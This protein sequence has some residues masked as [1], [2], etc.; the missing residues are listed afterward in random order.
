L[1]TIL[2]AVSLLSIILAYP[3]SA[4][5]RGSP[6]VIAEAG[7]GDIKLYN[8]LGQLIGG[9][10]KTHFDSDVG[11]EDALAVGDVNGDGLNDIV[12]AAASSDIIT[13]YASSRII[14]GPFKTNF[15]SDV[16]RWDALAVGD[17]DGDGRA[18][19]V[20]AEAPSGM[21]TIYNYL[22]Q[23]VGGPFKTNFDSDVG[24]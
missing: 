17:V 4:Q 2:L 6:I 9:P 11:G 20:I 21:V 3:A 19:I 12:I 7:S 13:I 1:V 5:R 18:E 8:E 14:G 22:G 23:V 24:G 10:F 16:G 15:D